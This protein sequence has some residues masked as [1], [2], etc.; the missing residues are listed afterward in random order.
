MPEQP[1]AVPPGLYGAVDLSGLAERAQSAGGAPGPAPRG[2]DPMA[3]AAE[4][5]ASGQTPVATLPDAVVDG[6]EQTLQ[7]FV[8]LSQFLPVLVEMHA[9]WSSEARE[10]SPQLARIVRSMQGRLVLV[11]ID[12]DAHPTLGQQPQVL[13]LLGGRP[14][15]LFSGNPPLEQLRGLLSELLQVAAEQG[16]AGRVQIE[17]AEDGEPQQ[18]PEPELPPLHRE[19]FEA[20]ERGDYAAGIAAFERAIAENPGDAEAQA[21]R[22]QLRL[23]QRL[24]GRTLDEVRAAA[25]QRPQDTD[26]QLAVADL[27]LSGGHVEDAFDRL[28]ALFPKLDAEG[29][30]RVR[31]RLLELF[32]I[33]GNEDPRVGAARRRLTNL[34]F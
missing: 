13:A 8:Q 2:E 12:L 16:L 3:D 5:A 10:L 23:L 14:L 28:L 25:A 31:E 27:D 21:G 4:A 1:P 34:L 26:A 22:A 19:A 15:Q 29:R 32:L 11:R 18:A 17:G 30:T 33:V 7:Q 20:A 9:G 24:Q 6:D